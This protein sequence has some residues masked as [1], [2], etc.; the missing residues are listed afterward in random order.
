MTVPELGLRERKRIATRGA[1]ERAALELA[2][3]N[4][5]EN[6]TVEDISAAAGVSPRTFF[7][8]FSTKE[9]AVVGEL[10]SLPRTEAFD[11]FLDAGPTEPVLDGVRDLLLDSMPDTAE[12]H[13][14]DLH[15]MRRDLLRENPQLFS[16][17]MASMRKLEL[18]LTELVQ[19][20][21]QRDDPAL[22]HDDQAARGR[23][24]LVALVAFAA[25]KHAWTCW[26]ETGGSGSLPQRLRS[27]FSELQTLTSPPLP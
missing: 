23:A 18:D 2:L 5:F 25:I 3:A 4:G 24:R 13:E 21:L 10:P 7:N 15:V 17:R 14:R 9:G 8:Y 16:L 6:V 26:A 22:A 27:S 12:P 19:R 20:R 11:R 1:I